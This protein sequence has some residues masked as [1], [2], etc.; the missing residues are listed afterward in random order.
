MLA[1]CATPARFEFGEKR[2]SLPRGPFSLGEIEGHSLF[3]REQVLFDSG[4]DKILEFRARPSRRELRPMVKIFGKTNRCSRS[5]YNV[6][7]VSH[8]L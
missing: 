5:V 4:G 3:C 7:F 2:E 8:T 6:H 1:A